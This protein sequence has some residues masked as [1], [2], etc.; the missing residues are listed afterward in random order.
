VWR[1]A[2]QCNVGQCRS[3]NL[4]HITSK[5]VLWQLLAGPTTAWL[6]STMPPRG[7]LHDCGRTKPSCRWSSKQLPQDFFGSDMSQVLRSTLP[8]ITLHGNTPHYI[9]APYYT[10]CFTRLHYTTLLQTQCTTLRCT[11]LPYPCLYNALHYTTL[12]TKLHYAIEHFTPL[13]K[14]F[15]Y[16]T[17]HN[18]TLHYATLH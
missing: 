13:H 3:K 9:E 2:V 8:Y 15:H 10:L 11:I 7:L 12:H 4:R 14:T 16:T 6:N 1:I 5:K 17:L 18:I